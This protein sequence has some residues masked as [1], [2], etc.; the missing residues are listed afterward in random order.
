MPKASK[1]VLIVDRV[2]KVR[3]RSGLY[4]LT[5]ESGKQRVTYAMSAYMAA[6]LMW[7]L[8]DGLQNAD[9]LPLP[10]AGGQR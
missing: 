10:Q 9:V 8:Q 1:R 2:E 4:E 3:V 7:R 6:R 5:F